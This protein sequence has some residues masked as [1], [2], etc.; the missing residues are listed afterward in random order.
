[1]DLV[2]DM[3]QSLPL[4][5]Q[6]VVAAGFGLIIGSFL[7]VY[8][9][10]LHTGRSLTGSSH[11]LSCATPLHWYELLPVVSYL[12]LRGRC[13][14]CGCQIPL[15]YALVEL[16]TGGLFV[17]GWLQ[18]TSLLVLLWWWLLVALLVV[19]VVYDLY[20]YIIP[21]ELTLAVL[22]VALGGLVM[23][24]WQTG[25]WQSVLYTIGAAALASLFLYSLW[26]WSGGRWLGFGDVKL[27]FP[28]GLLVG[29][30]EVFSLIVAAFWIGA[31]VSLGL[32]G[33][34]WWHTRGKPPL[35]ALPQS[36]TMKSAVP[37]APFLV[38]AALLVLFTDFNALSLFS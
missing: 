20:H 22:A 17:L 7:N 10:R 25:D 16:F 13:R 15:R 32:L 18:A 12:G 6:L 5:W 31:I 19:I 35:R 23:G 11:C 24:W 37:F 1:M 34:Q 8:I 14:S 21:D 2:W 33:F 28:L 38:A 30:T 36:F 26:W 27:I 3:L 29:Y 4:W 9:Y